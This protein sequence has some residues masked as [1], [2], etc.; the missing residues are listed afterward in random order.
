MSCHFLPAPNIKIKNVGIFVH[1]IND[2]GQRFKKWS[3]EGALEDGIPQREVSNY[4]ARA[5]T[6]L[7]HLG[8]TIIR[9]TE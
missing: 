8:A 3:G 9:P 1:D 7:T 4:P 2:T 5:T 6:Y